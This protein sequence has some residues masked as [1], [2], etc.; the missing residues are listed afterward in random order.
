MEKYFVR[1][2]TK[3]YMLGAHTREIKKNKKKMIKVI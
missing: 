3:S 1:H 2:N